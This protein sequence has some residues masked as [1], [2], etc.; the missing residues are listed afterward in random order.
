VFLVPAGVHRLVVL[1]WGAEGGTALGVP[2]SGYA[3]VEDDMAVR[4]GEQLYVEVGG[5]GADADAKS[6][7]GTPH[8][9]YAPGGFNGGGT[10]LE[11]GAGNT[12]GGGGG[13]SD[14]QLLPSRDG[15]AALLRRLVVAAGGGGAGGAGTLNDSFGGHGGDP[16]SAGGDGDS[17][18][19]ENGVIGGGG[20]GPGRGLAQ[21]GAGGAGGATKD[22]ASGQALNPAI[23][24]KGNA[25]TEGDIGKGGAGGGNVQFL[26]CQ[27]CDAKEGSGAGGGGGGGYAGGGGGG[28]GAIFE[29][30]K[31]MATAYHC[32][33]SHSPDAGG[34]GGGG[35]GSSEAN[36]WVRVFPAL[37]SGRLD[38]EVEILWDRPPP[39]PPTSGTS[40]PAT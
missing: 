34:G 3:E 1:A 8:C 25:G 21:V 13:A 7:P 24:F 39:R 17:V 28:S 40:V 6:C 16:G 38:G 37:G 26:S 22:P 35:G 23:Y 31:L 14:V 12:G 20:G 27:G 2:G 11:V 10:S 30:P 29:C 33:Q 36:A 9:R 5:K 32:D 15:E 18:Y 4:P 19:A